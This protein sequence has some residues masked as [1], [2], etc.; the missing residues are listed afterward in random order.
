MDLP[1]T[2]STNIIPIMSSTG[3]E[4]RLFATMP[5]EIRAKI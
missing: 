2:N 1:K 3:G 4:L 5:V